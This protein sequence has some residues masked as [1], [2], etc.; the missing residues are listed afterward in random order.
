M[1]KKL[2]T[3]TGGRAIKTYFRFLSYRLDRMGCG[4]LLLV[5]KDKNP[6]RNELSNVLFAI[7]SKRNINILT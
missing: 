6:G 2:A 4:G 5:G 7:D 3:N 1:P